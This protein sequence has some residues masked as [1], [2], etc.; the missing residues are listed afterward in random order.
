LIG[1]SALV[2][3]LVSFFGKSD[4]STRRWNRSGATPGQKHKTAVLRSELRA[5]KKFTHGDKAI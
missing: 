3:V 1:I 4:S 2:S 5:D